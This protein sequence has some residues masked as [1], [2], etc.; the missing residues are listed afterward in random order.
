MEQLGK[1]SAFLKGKTSLKQEICY[2]F[3][4]SQSEKLSTC[5]IP[6]CM[7][8]FLVATILYPASLEKNMGDGW[9]K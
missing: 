7:E 2:V 3:S 8:G 4:Q 1:K 6:I 9:V 5:F